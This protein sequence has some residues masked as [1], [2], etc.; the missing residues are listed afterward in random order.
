[1]RA[2]REEARRGNAPVV[3]STLVSLLVIA[4]A[5]AAVAYLVLRAPSEA[6]DSAE[7]LEPVGTAIPAPTEQ[8]SLPTA[9][10]TTNPDPE[11]TALA[12]S[13]DAPA[14]P[15]PP[16]LPTAAAPVETVNE[17]AGPTPTPRVIAP[18]TA[19]PPT[20]PPAAP[21][22]PP[23]PPT[24]EVPVVALQPVE[25]AP[26]PTA[27]PAPAVRSVSTAVPTPE[28]SDPLNVLQPRQVPRIVPS[29]NEALERARDLQRGNAD[30]GDDNPGSG[31]G[32]VVPTPIVPVIVPTIAVSVASAPDD[33][34]EIVMPD[35]SATIEAITARAIDPNRNPNV[36]DTGRSRAARNDDR[37]RGRDPTPTP[38]DN[39]RKKGRGRD[40]R[41]PSAPGIQNGRGPNIPAIQPGGPGNR[42]NQDDCR[43]PFANLPKDKQPKNFPFDDC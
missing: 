7:R 25:A 43:N 27:A 23:A 12:F 20:V 30:D 39:K 33:P 5:V 13:G 15:A 1:M 32:P 35:V 14:A 38:D 10:P 28:D 9:V 11:P 34:I 29:A 2:E 22:L 16:A 19:V 37:D 24:A 18:P 21:T 26:Q 4:A 31:R 6:V 40:D 36:N 41:S 8:P 17:A 3:I 42:D